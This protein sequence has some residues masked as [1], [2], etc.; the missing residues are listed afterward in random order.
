[1]FYEVVTLFIEGDIFKIGEI[2]YRLRLIN[3]HDMCWLEPVLYRN[4]AH[5]ITSGLNRVYHMDDLDD[6]EYLHIT[7]Y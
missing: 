3:K 6:L 7:Y 4:D 5:C 1:M 2:E